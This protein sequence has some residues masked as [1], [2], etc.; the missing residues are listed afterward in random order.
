MAV[1]NV[2]SSSQPVSFAPSW[3]LFPLT[4]SSLCR[5]SLTRPLFSLEG[6][7]E[8]R[9][10]RPV[11]KGQGFALQ[12]EPS[13]YLPFQPDLYSDNIELSELGT[14]IHFLPRW[15]ILNP[16]NPTNLSILAAR[17]TSIRTGLYI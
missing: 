3:S 14:T 7:H 17:L 10:A 2:A 16:T 4:L 11:S 5:L 8:Q 13:L 15:L 12:I 1:F 9:G 6:L